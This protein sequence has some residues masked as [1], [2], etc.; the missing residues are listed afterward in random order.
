M[1]IGPPLSEPT[2]FRG[3]S[4]LQLLD[5]LDLDGRNLLDDG[6][7]VLG[8]N[9]VEQSWH[10]GASRTSLK[11]IGSWFHSK[12]M[13]AASN[14]VECISPRSVDVSNGFSEPVHD[15]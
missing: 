10:G 15:C 7:D 2:E 6:G 8:A 3:V 11:V 4:R 13:H 1:S 5:V 9:L 12:T 14:F